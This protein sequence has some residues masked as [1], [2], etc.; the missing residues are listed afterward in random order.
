[1]LVTSRRGRRALLLLGLTSATAPAIARAQ[2]AA[3]LPPAKQI[4]DRYIKETGG[5]E[6]RKHKSGRMKATA[7]VPGA[8]TASVEVMAIFPTAVAQKMT[9]PG[10]GDI[11]NGW[12]GTMAWSVNPM[13]GP[14][15][16]TGA[17]A[18][19]MKEDA[20]PENGMRVSPNIVSSETVEK[21]SVNGVD[22]YKVKHTW[23]S[24]RVATDCY[25]V[26]DGLLVSTTTK[27]AT[28]MGEVE[29]T[30]YVANY[31]E[32][33]GVK[34]PTTITQEAMG[35]RMVLTITAWE[36]DNVD[37]KEVE[38]PAAVKALKKP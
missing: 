1:M 16:L 33:G 23:K 13:M 9:V 27:Q 38:P 32:F 14:Q 26:A 28:Q 29:T 18:E 11:T 15:I 21:A 35:Q 22:C 3:A 12:D 4:I 8:G 36:W 6:W 5:N 24:G 30:Q 37:A 31:K 34:R 17:Q 10:L 19:A 20:D 7:E 25:S 2:G